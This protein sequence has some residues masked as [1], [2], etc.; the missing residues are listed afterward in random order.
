[1][2][3]ASKQSQIDNPA[4]L[5]E[6]VASVAKQNRFLLHSLPESS[7]RGSGQGNRGIRMANLMSHSTPGEFQ[8]R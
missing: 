4:Y 3:D 7:S 6:M 5:A 1:M 8:Q 2:P